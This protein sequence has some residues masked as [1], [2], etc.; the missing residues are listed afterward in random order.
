MVF[1]RAKQTKQ[2]C[3]RYSLTIL[4]ITADSNFYIFLHF[5]PLFRIYFATF[6]LSKVFIIF[7]DAAE[8][9]NSLARFLQGKTN[10]NGKTNVNGKCITQVGLML[11]AGGLLS[12]VL[13][14]NSALFV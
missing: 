7:G 11:A 5:R 1:C 13:C 10:G 6:S 8:G 3:K 4:T 9:A 14:V 2:A 12:W